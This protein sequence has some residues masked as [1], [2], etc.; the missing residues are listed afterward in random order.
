MDVPYV[1]S[2][3]NDTEQLWVQDRYKYNVETKW[4]AVEDDLENCQASSDTFSLNFTSTSGSGFLSHPK[5]YA[6]YINQQLLDYD[7]A[8]GVCYGVI[9]VDYGTQEIAEHIYETNF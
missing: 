8:Q 4:D 5:G 2:M 3:I 1:N 9:I 7:L 6:K